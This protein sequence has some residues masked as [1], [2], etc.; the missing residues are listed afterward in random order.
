MS[1][2]NDRKGVSFIEEQRIYYNIS[3]LRNTE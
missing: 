3:A 1:K 2:G